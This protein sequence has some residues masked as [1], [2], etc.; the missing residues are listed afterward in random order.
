MRVLVLMLMFVGASLAS[1]Q[2][3]VDELKARLLHKPLF[4]SGQWGE[5]KLVFDATGRLVGTAARFPFTLS[6]I[7]VDS[8]RL[9]AKGLR[10][11][12]KRAGLVFTKGKIT[13]QPLGEDIR[14]QIAA[15]ATGDYTQA[16]DAIFYTSASDYVPSLPAYWK[17]AY[18]E[19]LLTGSPLPAAAKPVSAPGT[20]RIG[21]AVSAPRALHVA[22]PDFNEYARAVRF[23]GIV[24]IYLQVDTAGNPTDVRILHPIGLG[25]D[26]RAVAAVAKYKFKP[27]AQ[28]G[29]PVRVEMNV[30]VNFQSF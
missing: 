18:T 11:D 9:D 4:L 5:R 1:A 13:R 23:S 10:I 28:N 16:L 24:L 27:A 22:D 26:E 20:Q 7:D 8:V 21:G 2:T 3:S 25:L 17:G 30:E 6:G 14:L 15:P 29:L 12:G 19:A